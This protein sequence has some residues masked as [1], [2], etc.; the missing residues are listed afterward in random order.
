MGTFVTINGTP[1]YQ[2]NHAQD[3]DPFFIH[4]VSASD[5]WIFLS[6]KGGITAGRKNAG[7]AVFPY[8]TDD[9]LHQAYETGSKTMIRVDNTI[10]EP[11]ERSCVRK[12]NITQNIY[13]S[14]YGNSIILEEINHD[15]LLSFSY[16]LEGSEQFGIVKTSRLK[17]LRDQTVLVH[18]LDGMQNILP[19]GVNENLL[20][21]G[22]TL[23]D[24]YKANEFADQNL[25]VYSLT[26]FINDTP[27]PIEVLKANIA[28]TTERDAAVYM[29]PDIIAD[30]CQNKELPP[31][32]NCYGRKGGFFVRYQTEL[33]SGEEKM[34]S[35]VL[36]S[37]YDHCKITSLTRY[38]S[39]G[40]FEA[41]Y[42]DIEKGTTQLKRIVEQADG[43][44]SG[45]DK[46]ACAHHF[47]NTLYNV[48]RGGT[49]EDGYQFHPGDFFAFVQHRNKN[50]AHNADF[51]ERIQNCTD[52]HMLKD[53]AKDDPVMLRL[54]LEY[55]PLSFSR[56]HGD[57]SRPWNRFNIQTKDEN[58]HKVKR[59]EGNWR[60]IFQNW[61]ALGLSFPCYY[62]NMVAKFVNAS[63]IDGFNPYRIDNNGFDWE[64]P[65]PDN[66]FS[67]LGYWGDHQIVYLLRLL[68]GLQN[69]FPYRLQRLLEMPVFSY[70]NVPYQIKP[71]EEILQNSKYTIVYDREKDHSIALL[72]DEIGTDGMLCQQN[73]AV[74]TVCLTEKLLVPLL[75]KLCNLYPGGGIWMN[76]QRPEWN[77]ANNAI[78]GIGLSM[79]TVYHM[80]SYIHFMQ[81]IF[82]EQTGA[83]S[84]SY[85][86]ADWLRH[87]TECLKSYQN[88]YENNEKQILDS[89]GMIFSAY[90]TK[91]YESG[92]SEKTT[93]SAS[94]IKDLLNEGES[95]VRYTI[96]KNRGSVY[97][98]Y[99]LLDSNR[100][101]AALYPMLEGQSAV[102]G[103][104]TLSSHE[105]C[106][107]LHGMEESLYNP[108]MQF[109]YLY[110]VK[111]TTPFAEKNKLQNS[112][113]PI[114]SIV[115]KDDN[116][117]LHFA[118]H[119]TTT[120]I[121][122]KALDEIQIN[123]EQKQ[124]LMEEYERIFAHKSF[125]GR[126]GVMYK[127]E[128]IGCVYWHQNAKLAL[129]V[130]ENVQKARASQEDAAE[131]Y[132][133]YKQ[134][135]KGFIYRK[136]PKECGAI[137]IEPYSHTS[138]NQKSE[139][140][141][142]TGQVK[143]MLLMR[144]GELG[145][146]VQNGCICF[147]PWFVSPDEY[148]ENGTFSFTI[149]GI[150]TLYKKN[151]TNHLQIIYHDGSSEN[152]ENLIIPSKI[153]EDIF[154]RKGKIIKIIV[155]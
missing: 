51:F 30:F 70:A 151:T 83:Y 17:N 19:Y 72:C 93:I 155:N 10:W 94:E 149:C 108:K 38:L 128:G 143:E 7:G 85:E 58:G 127:Y 53:C 77:D 9:R 96:Q 41:L 34:H 98:T 13:K 2:I 26:T 116:G 52:V 109:H 23:V 137:P 18:I 125:T 71:Y 103:S 119:L 63:T 101:V 68:L 47:I 60:D 40:N 81:N 67:G 69:H 21:T 106:S 35:I 79:V 84:L 25:A 32:Q 117:Q 8:E 107:L 153:S 95:V 134:L 11:F 142:M 33:A 3:M 152:L 135:T 91:V 5:I 130:L 115:L 145:V 75:A 89:L 27:D 105:V 55:M 114:A 87:V 50:A 1:Y 136:T 120:A 48:M 113:T 133:A 104:K 39:R 15:L 80:Q 45:G 86:V 22:S 28:W 31:P 44:Q 118:P 66:P 110:P 148:D 126:S 76:T 4:V 150:Q 37:S 64:R 124:R 132:K 57:P 144:R 82:A 62:E 12:W 138:F 61:E 20:A 140:P 99:N 100:S 54:A 49:F 88:Q 111:M 24:A 78:V 46:I 147:D 14:V 6:S 146:T 56:R 102:I 123:D 90:R 65:E 43:M 73:A 122:T 141:G 139:Q 29:N 59:Y 97:T 131:I 121:L 36:D 92:F 74:Y 154:M 129:A 16:Q 42:A 112:F